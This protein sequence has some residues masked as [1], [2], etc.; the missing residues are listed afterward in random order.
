[1]VNTICREIKKAPYGNKFFI[2]ISVNDEKPVRIMKGKMTYFFNSE[3]EAESHA[4]KIS[5]RIIKKGI[6]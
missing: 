3:K 4:L 5:N 1:M 6:A 2:E